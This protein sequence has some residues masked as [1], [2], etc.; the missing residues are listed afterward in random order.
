MPDNLT[1][2]ARHDRSR[3]SLQEPDQLRYWMDAL[4]VT[5]TQL[6]QAVGKVGDSA[7]AVRRELAG[8]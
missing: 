2:R 1:N 7:E 8:Q 5:R 6:E 4:R 3:V